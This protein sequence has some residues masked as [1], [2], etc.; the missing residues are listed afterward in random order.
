MVGIRGFLGDHVHMALDNYAPAVFHTGSGGN[1]DDYVAAFVTDGFKTV[2]YAPVV[3]IFN[4][5][6]LM[7]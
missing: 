2:A 6:A 4:H 3:K 7:L 5:F 1:A